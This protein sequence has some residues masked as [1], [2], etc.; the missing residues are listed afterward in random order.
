MTYEEACSC[1]DAKPRPV[2]TKTRPSEAKTRPSANTK[3][4]GPQGKSGPVGTRG[5]EGMEA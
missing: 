4:R 1:A 2:V 5:A 3:Y